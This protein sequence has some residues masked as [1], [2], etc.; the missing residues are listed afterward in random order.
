MYERKELIEYIKSNEFSFK[1]VSLNYLKRGKIYPVLILCP[2]TFPNLPNIDL[3]KL[4]N[5]QLAENQIQLINQKTIKLNQICDD[6]ISL[7][8]NNIDFYIINE[9]SLLKIGIKIDFP[10][11]LNLIYYEENEKKFLFFI[12]ES[13]LLLLEKTNFNHQN[14]INNINYQNLILELEQ[15]KNKNLQLINTINHLKEELN[16]AK[17][18]NNNLSNIIS[19]NTIKIS[20]LSNLINVKDREINELKQKINNNFNMNNS[21]RNIRPNEVIMAINFT[22]FDQK[23]HYCLPCKNS[24]IFV[25]LEEQLY[26]EYPDYKEYDNIYFMSNANRIKRFKS[27]DEN[28]IKSGDTIILNFFDIEE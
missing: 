3:K 19:Q 13:R 17:M 16:N 6:I 23:F 22:S 7:L 21:L 27:L 12:N 10:I 2:N 1:E 26:R 24:D 25:K 20:E 9:L 14:N 28:K 5:N 4:I 8:N 15:E 11:Q 18:N